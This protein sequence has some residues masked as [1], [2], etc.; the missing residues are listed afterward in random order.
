MVIFFF[1]PIFV[2]LIDAQN[3][4]ITSICLEKYSALSL[5]ELWQL[6]QFCPIFQH[7]HKVLID[8]CSLVC[9]FTFLKGHSE[10]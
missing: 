7:I 10:I 9:S 5:Y 4:A 3:S 8:S 2:S 1:F 6:L